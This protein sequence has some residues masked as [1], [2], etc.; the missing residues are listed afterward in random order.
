MPD[1]RPAEVAIQQA[2]QLSAEDY[3]PVELARAEQRLA[4]ARKA[5][6]ARKKANAEMLAQQA[7]LEALVAQARSRAAAGRAQVNRKTEENAR[8]RRDLLGQGGVE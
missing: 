6:A 7:E 4:E 3:A 8:L 1:M 5:L 2:R